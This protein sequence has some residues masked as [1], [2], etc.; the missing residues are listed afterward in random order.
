MNCEE[1]SNKRKIV[2]TKLKDECTKYNKIDNEKLFELSNIFVRLR[3]QISER[4]IDDIVKDILYEYDNIQ[5]EKKSQ[6][7]VKFFKLLLKPKPRVNAEK[8]KKCTSTNTSYSII[9]IRSSDEPMTKIIT[10]LDC[11][12]TIREDA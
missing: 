8:C 11:G 7:D 6:R 5:K 12:F 4:N 1:Y 9:Q 10:C 3:N 2:L